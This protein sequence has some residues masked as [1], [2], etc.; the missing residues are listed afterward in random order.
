MARMGIEALVRRKSTSRPAAGHEIDPYLLR[1]V[2][3]ERPNHVWALDI[4]S[5]TEGGFFFLHAIAEG[6]LFSCSLRS[7]NSHVVLNKTT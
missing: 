3:I 5:N 6:I 4:L 2:V 7:R 1:N